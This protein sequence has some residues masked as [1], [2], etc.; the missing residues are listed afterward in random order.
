[1]RKLLILLALTFV[2]FVSPAYEITDMDA[3]TLATLIETEKDY[4]DAVALFEAADNFEQLK[5]EKAL[6]TIL[7]VKSDQLGTEK[8]N[9]TAKEAADSTAD[10][11]AKKTE[12]VPSVPNLD[13]DNPVQICSDTEGQSSSGSGPWLLFVFGFFGGLFALFTP[14]V[15]PMI[16]LTVSF[17]T[18]GGSDKGGVVRAILYGFFIFLIYASLSIPFHFGSDPEVLNQLSTNWILNLG[19]FL[20]FMFFAFSFFGYYELTLPS[21]WS[22]KTD[23][24]AN[25]GGLLGIF[26][27]ALTLAIVSFSCTGPILGSVLANSLTDGPWPITAA[28]S[29][30]G[31]ALGGPFAIFA[32]FP[33]LMSKLPQSGGWL[34]AVKVNL[35]FIEIALAF[36]FLSVA[37]L[38]MHWG[39]LKIELFLIAWIICAVGLA[40]YAWGKL[41]FPHDSPITKLSKGRMILGAVYALMAVY[42]VSGFRYNE[43]SETFVSLSLISGLAPPSGYSWIHPGHCP[44]GLNCYHDFESAMEEAKKQNK[45]IMIDFTGYGCVNCR[46]MEENVWSQQKVFDLINDD[47]ILVSLYVDDR[48]LLPEDQQGEIMVTLSDGATKKKRIRTVGDKWSA[49][50]ITHFKQIAQPFYFLLTPDGELLNNPVGYT[51]D[52]DEYA[53]WLKCGLEAFEKKK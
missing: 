14:C 11:V 34:N 41:R 6:V 4:T 23:D 10:P 16:P 38:V 37:D 52:T 50:E 5:A 51:P 12:I 31:V 8:I 43:K 20:I 36:K 15:F 30:F 28:M 44:N 32:M 22:N 3:T 2:G 39:I 13:L 45:P 40:L 48:E 25:T 18:K 24:A 35:G 29:G 7:N 46:K 17:F 19:F 42:F 33:K 21:K 47:Y 26:F 9:W 1:M 53:A 49:F 27:M